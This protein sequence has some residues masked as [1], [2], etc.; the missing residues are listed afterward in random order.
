MNQIIALLFLLLATSCNMQPKETAATIVQSSHVNAVRYGM[1]TGVKPE[2]LDYYKQLHAKP[3]PQV[4]NKIKECNIQ[5][6]SIYLQ[7]IGEQNFLFSYFEYTG[8]D[9]G[10]DM[11]KMAADSV[12]QRWWRE[13]DPCQLPLQ[14]ALEKHEIWTSMQEVFHAD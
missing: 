3:W 10:K 7:K 2:K 5:N 4:L 6:Y 13:T 11:Q 1:I 8:N 14:E 12:T 9:F